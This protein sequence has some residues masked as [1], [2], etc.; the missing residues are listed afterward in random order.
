ML[1]PEGPQRLESRDKIANPKK[2]KLLYFT[3]ILDPGGLQGY[4]REY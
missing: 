4:D 2:I 1:D 3:Q